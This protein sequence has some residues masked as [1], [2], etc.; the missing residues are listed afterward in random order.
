M[1]HCGQVEKHANCVSTGTQED[2]YHHSVLYNGFTS[3]LKSELM[4][5]FGSEAKIDQHVAHM[6]SL[7]EIGG[8]RK[9]G[10]CPKHQIPS[11]FPEQSYWHS[12]TMYPSS[13]RSAPMKGT[14]PAKTTLSTSGPLL[15]PNKQYLE[16]QQGNQNVIT[17]LVIPSAGNEGD[18]STLSQTIGSITIGKGD[19]SG[20]F[21]S[22]HPP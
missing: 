20:V 7:F 9:S 16:N 12:P 5:I 2:G 1:S 13:S 19:L 8:Q 15:P 14:T 3:D 6:R 22:L 18:V 10:R 11:R 17:P 4:K 21:P